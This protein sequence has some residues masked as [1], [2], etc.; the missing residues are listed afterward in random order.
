MKKGILSVGLCDQVPM[1]YDDCGVF[2]ETP[3]NIL[4]GTHGASS[5][6]THQ[7]TR[8]QSRFLQSTRAKRVHTPPTNVGMQFPFQA[9][10]SHNT[11]TAG[12]H[13][14]VCVCGV[15]VRLKGLPGWLAMR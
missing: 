11:Q 13:K 1:D 6:C 7:Q 2:C 15:G 4:R 9:Q 5:N 3:T 10:P 8:F 14:I 12:N